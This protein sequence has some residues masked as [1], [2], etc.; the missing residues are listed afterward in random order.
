VFAPKDLNHLVRNLRERAAGNIRSI[1]T[2]D[3]QRVVVD[4]SD[5]LQ[6]GVGYDYELQRTI[7]GWEI[8]G[9]GY[10]RPAE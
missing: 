9:V 10:R 6:A 2:D 1:K 3:G 8:I 4:F 5:S 7:N